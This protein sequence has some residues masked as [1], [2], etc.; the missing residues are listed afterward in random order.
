MSN[1]DLF[2]I[3]D[4]RIQQQIYSS[5]WNWAV[6]NK[7]RQCVMVHFVVIWAGAGGWWGYSGGGGTNRSW[8]WSGGSGAVVRAS[9]PA[10]MLPDTLYIYVGRWWAGGAAWNNGLNGELS[11]I[12]LLPNNTTA[13]SLVLV[14]GAAVPTWGG[15]GWAGTNS[16]AWVGSAIM[17]S[18]NALYSSWCNFV[19]V[20]WPAWQS[21]SILQTGTDG[22]TTTFIGGSASWGGMWGDNLADDNGGAVPWVT[23]LIPTIPWWVSG[24]ATWAAGWMGMSLMW[25]MIFQGSAWGWT[26]T[27]TWG[28]GGAWRTGCWGGGWGVG[29]TTWG[30]G[31]NG[32]PWLVM[33]TCI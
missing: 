22:T 9:V 29:G 32:W 11:Y 8:G 18:T 19:A 16:A 27:T 33:I 7:P 3:T 14:S 30:A 10:Y 25:A 2:H 26:W 21:G 12:S 1:Y 20:A 15:A 4:K 24:W 17:A 13:T 5:P 23:N 28:A 31:W 6:W